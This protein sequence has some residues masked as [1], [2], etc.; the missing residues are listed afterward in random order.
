VAQSF[1]EASLINMGTVAIAV[2]EPMP[3]AARLAE[4]DESDDPPPQAVSVAIIAPH[5]VQLS[6]LV[7]MILPRWRCRRLTQY[8]RISGGNGSQ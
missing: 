7:S 2:C 4:L 3:A 8:V 5:T 6:F 1:E